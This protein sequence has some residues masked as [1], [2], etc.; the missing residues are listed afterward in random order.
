MAVEENNYALFRISIKSK[1]NKNILYKFLFNHAMK[2]LCPKDHILHPKPTE[3]PD[4]TSIDH[5]NNTSL[6]E[7][8]EKEMKFL[9]KNCMKTYNDSKNEP[10]RHKDIRPINEKSLYFK[11]KK[12]EFEDKHFLFLDIDETLLHA[13]KQ[14]IENSGVIIVK[15]IKYYVSLRPYLREF[16]EKARKDFNVILYTAGNKYYAKSISEFLGNEFKMV[17]DREHCIYNYVFYLKDIRILGYDLSKTFIIDND[18][19][20]FSLTPENG[21]HIKDYVVGYN[22]KELLKMINVLDRIANAK[23]VRTVIADLQIN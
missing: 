2:I 20:A 6:F 23:D 14:Q 9:V 22:D 4:E 18:R 17:L 1:N 13:S 5:K 21:I 11:E 19:K 3:L 8:N 15:S 7:K 16:L 10:L 12:I